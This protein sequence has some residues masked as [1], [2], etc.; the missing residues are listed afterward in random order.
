[1]RSQNFTIYTVMWVY[2]TWEEQPWEQ[3][4]YN[5]VY[6]FDNTGKVRIM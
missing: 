4:L 2:I 6:S 3:N 1:L 5:Y